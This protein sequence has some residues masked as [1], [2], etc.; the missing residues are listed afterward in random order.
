MNPIAICLSLWATAAPF[1][2]APTDAWRQYA[3]LDAAGWSSAKLAEARAVADAAGSASVFAVHDGV[4]VAAVQDDLG[5]HVLRRPTE[6]PRLASETDF[7]G[8]T[9]VHLYAKPTCTYE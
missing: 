2:D 6:R 3:D 4:V 1:A 7:F 5:R 9:E 8:E